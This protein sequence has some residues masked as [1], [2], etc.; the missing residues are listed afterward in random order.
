MARSIWVNTIVLCVCVL[1]GVDAA[2]AQVVRD[3][4]VLK[5]RVAAVQPDVVQPKPRVVNPRTLQ[6]VSPFI[7]GLRKEIT[8]NSGLGPNFDKPIPLISTIN[9]SQ[10]IDLELNDVLNIFEDVYPDKNPASGL[11]YFLPRL[12]RLDWEAEQGY[13]MRMMYNAS[14]TE[15]RVGDVMITARLTAS[16][17]NAEIKLAQALLAAAG[18]NVK[19][20][21]A[22]PLAGPPEV[23]LS[24]GLR[25]LFNIP[26]ERISSNPTSEALGEIDIA[27]VT[28]TVTK[29]NIE[30]ALTEQVG[31]S[32]TLTFTP[33]G[34]ATRKPQ[35]PIKIA[36]A[37]SDTL[38]RFRWVREQN[39][40]NAAP[41]PLRLKYLHA[42]ILKDNKPIIY[43]WGLGNTEILPT[44]QVQWDAK[45]IP[46]WI[47]K[48]AKRVWID[49]AIKP[50]CEACDKQVIATI[51][52]G[53]SN[54]TASPILFETI[55]PLA[56][57]GAYKLMVVVRSSYL[58]P[59]SRELQTLPDVSLNKDEQEFRSGVVYLSDRQSGDTAASEPIFEY[60]LSV[61]MRDGVVHQSSK[62]I[63]S[64]NLRVLIGSAQIKAAL[65]FVPGTT[66]S[67]P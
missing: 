41:Y 27:W 5:D 53:V 49:Y 31:I 16:V 62:W 21:R 42:L 6:T 36:I 47:E 39:W 28:D 65:G 52:S 37:D 22:V 15:G 45:R 34:A 54:I 48:E 26:A 30:L 8:D 55:T 20:L 17:D 9:S 14:A 35:I 10:S 38:G 51:T 58:N 25:A 11:F 3:H 1:A 18:H 56:D 32:G 24:G 63:P 57:T 67:N 59:R 2:P 19:V 12:Y 61:V 66:P 50:G 7:Y 4:R 46:S 60:L 29:E 40:R 33:A 64:Q 23:S 13:G 44:A 43:S